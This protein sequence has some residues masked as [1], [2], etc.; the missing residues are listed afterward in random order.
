LNYLIGSIYH[1]EGIVQQY[2]DFSEEDEEVLNLAD[3]RKVTVS[4]LNPILLAVKYRS[5]AVLK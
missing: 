5:L 4:I 3:D 2:F 1:I